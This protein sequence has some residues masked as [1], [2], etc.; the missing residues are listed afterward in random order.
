MPDYADQGTLAAVVETSPAD[1]ELIAAEIKRLAAALARPGGVTAEALEQ[2]RK[3]LL[4][5]RA[6]ERETN[7]WWLQTLD[8]SARHPEWLKDSVEWERDIRS[9]RLEEVQ[10]AA[11]KWLTRPTV[12]TLVTPRTTTAQAPAPATAAA[13]P[14]GS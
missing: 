3:P 13:A 4:D 6:K 9:I 7:T 11:S 2:A 12:T 1:A 8:G 14:A 10:A 5:G